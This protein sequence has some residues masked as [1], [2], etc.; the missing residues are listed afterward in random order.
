MSKLTF[1]TSVLTGSVPLFTD[2]T[3]GSIAFVAVG[4]T[5]TIVFY[6]IGNKILK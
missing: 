2:G 1:A 4:A 3:K 5:A 6:I